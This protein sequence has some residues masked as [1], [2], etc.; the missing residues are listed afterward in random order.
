[1]LKFWLLLEEAGCCAFPLSDVQW[2]SYLGPQ[3]LR[4]GR[5]GSETLS[6]LF[7]EFKTFGLEM[8][9][10]HLW[11]GT[12]R[13]NLGFK[14]LKDCSS[15]CCCCCYPHKERRQICIPNSSYSFLLL[16]LWMKW[17]LWSLK[18]DEHGKWKLRRAESFFLLRKALPGDQHLLDKEVSA[19]TSISQSSGQ[20]RS[21]ELD[22]RDNWD[23][24]G[25]KS[26][27]QNK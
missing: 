24:P 26:A 20:E 1:M 7:S 13:M 21:A 15:H 4:A 6:W 19:S 8:K 17:A 3:A 2:F 5:F 11:I 9:H 27:S 16:L 10:L 18:E 14:L 25:I 12:K 23:S 22:C